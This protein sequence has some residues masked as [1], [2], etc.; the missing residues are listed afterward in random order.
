M[1]GGFRLKRLLTL[2]FTLV[3]LLG[4]LVMPA[5]AESAAS[6]VDLYC[7][8][9]TDGDCLVTMQVTLR[10]E[11]SYDSLSF[12]LPATAKSIT[13]NGSNVSSTRTDSAVMVDISRITRDY[14]GDAI[15]RFEYTIPDAVRVN[16]ESVLEKLKNGEEL[17][18][19]L[20]LEIPMLC[21][22][23][24][25]VESLKFTVTMPNGAMTNQPSFT[26]TYRQASVESDL[27]ILITDNQIIGSSKT[28][29]N[30]RDGMTMT[31]IV[32]ES[33]FPTVSTYVRNGNPELTYITV[34]AVLALLYWLLR[35]RTLPIHRVDATT[36]PEGV[37][38]GELGCRLTLCGGD[39]TMMVFTWAQLG[40]LILS[41][42]ENGKVLLHKRMD[43]GNER[44]P[45]ENKIFRLLF[46]NRRV[47]DATGDTYAKLCLKTARLV[48]Q[49]KSMYKGSSGNIKIFRA[50]AC[51][52]QIFAGICV[53]M[54]LSET[55]WLATIMAVILGVVGAVTGWLIQDMAY[56][57]H[58]RGKVPVLLGLVSILL[59]TVLGLLSG[60]VWIPLGVSLGQWVYGYFAAYGGR[61]TD[62]GRHDAGQ[63]LGLRQ[64][65]KHVP[66]SSINRL[67]MNDPDY[68]FNYA[69]YAIALGVMGPFGRAFGGR[70]MEQCPYLVANVTDCRTA[71][72]WGHLL[73]DTADIMDAKSRRM[74][75]ERWIPLQVNVRFC[76]RK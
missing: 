11:N 72:E 45:F 66:K 15:L 2:L 9:N 24:L 57:T 42:D 68:F 1:L 46:G 39:L 3:L 35:L 36:S 18:D 52:C 49:R 21:G 73:Q 6:T 25:P 76:K 30:D 75:I 28:A 38:A 41:V 47:I 17:T 70:K 34:F 43:M 13:L 29:M 33:M 60:Q 26:S 37:T 23:E 63:V 71:E 4:V 55:L 54:N 8:V 69:P 50:L 7:T 58:L 59:W 53:A 31:M 20:I 44:G 10:L 22:F 19:R 74:Q 27:N 67:L 56:R 5:S 51:V 32:P 61:R 12:P 64:H 65:L 16:K 14:L 62:L 40:Y 48:P